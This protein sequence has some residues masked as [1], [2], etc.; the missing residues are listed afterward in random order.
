MQDIADLWMSYKDPRGRPLNVRT[1]WAKQWQ[2]LTLRD[3]PAVRHLRGEPVPRE[4]T[5]PVEIV[6]AAN[7][8]VA[9]QATLRAGVP[10]RVTVTPPPHPEPTQC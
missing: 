9:E 6:D 3:R 7:V 5:L 4:I 1:H 10:V 8:D 2:G